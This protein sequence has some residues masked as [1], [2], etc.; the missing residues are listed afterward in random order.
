[1]DEEATKLVNALL[2]ELRMEHTKYDLDWIDPS[3]SPELHA[4]LVQVTARHID[5][6][7]FGSE[8]PGWHSNDA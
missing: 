1:M 2:H 4:K 8:Q 6:I 7:C 3:T 5:V